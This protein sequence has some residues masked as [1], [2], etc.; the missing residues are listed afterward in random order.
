MSSGFD[1]ADND[2]IPSEDGNLT[3]EQNKNSRQPM[4]TVEKSAGKVSRDCTE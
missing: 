2:E 3:L 4:L 1:E